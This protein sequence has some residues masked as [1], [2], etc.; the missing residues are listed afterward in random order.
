MAETTYISKLRGQLEDVE[1]AIAAI[2]ANGQEHSLT[3]SHSFKGVEY[4]V[5][6]RERKTIEA[7]IA[8]AN[9]GSNVTIPDYS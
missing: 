2:L 1:A 3:G 5:L 7:K 4:S 8:A 9:G 6:L